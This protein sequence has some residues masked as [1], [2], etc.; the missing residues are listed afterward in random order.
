MIIALCL[1]V[2]VGFG[3]G[4]ACGAAKA[5]RVARYAADRACIEATRLA[6]LR[7]P[8][9]GWADLHPWAASAIATAYALTHYYL[10]RPGGEKPGWQTVGLGTLLVWTEHG[11]LHRIIPPGANARSPQEPH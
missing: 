9:D 4:Y 8:T 6:Q 3:V 10:G 5:L 7:I 11:T 1:A 2:C